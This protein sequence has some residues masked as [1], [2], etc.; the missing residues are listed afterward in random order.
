MWTA[1]TGLLLT[2]SRE[3]Q[4]LSAAEAPV[5]GAIDWPLRD[6]GHNLE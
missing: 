4:R 5:H 6:P 3:K 2:V 1:I